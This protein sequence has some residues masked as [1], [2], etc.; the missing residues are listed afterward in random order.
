M[1]DT[2]ITYTQTYPPTFVAYNG[3]V[4]PPFDLIRLILEA[5]DDLI[6][7]EAFYEIFGY[8]AVRSEVNDDKG[9]AY[10][11]GSSQFAAR[12]IGA[13][14]EDDDLGAD[15]GL[16]ADF[17][18][19]ET[20]FGKH[21]QTYTDGKEWP[22]PDKEDDKVADYPLRQWDEADIKLYKK[23]FYVLLSPTLHAMAFELPIGMGGS[24]QGYTGWSTLFEE[25]KK[26][27]STLASENPP[28]D[29]PEID[30]EDAEIE[31]AK[32]AVKI[33]AILKG[34]SVVS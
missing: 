19:T 29:I 28:L 25:M 5:E 11:G 22:D 27:T 32:L 21:S 16:Q 30:Q 13:G 4:C 24:M 1:A 9:Q 31:T 12:L 33:T 14:I 18:M 6:Q 34:L 2:P 20:L 15:L 17:Q 26:M 8:E 23:V 10:F 3:P 7:Q